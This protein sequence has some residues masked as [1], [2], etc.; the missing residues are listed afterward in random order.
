MAP[1]LFG[2]LPDAVAQFGV[3]ALGAS[4]LHERAHDHDVRGD[5]ARAAE[6]AREHGHAL[7]GKCVGEIAPA[8]V[9]KLRASSALSWN[10][11]SAG[12]RAPLRRTA[13]FRRLVLTP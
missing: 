13:S 9:A 8:P 4:Q 5:R 10:M 12:K 6:H 1:Q 11:K 3:S 7:F 2:E